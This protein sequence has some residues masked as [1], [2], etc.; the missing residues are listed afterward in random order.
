MIAVLTPQ[1]EYLWLIAV[2]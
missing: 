1:Q 2:Y